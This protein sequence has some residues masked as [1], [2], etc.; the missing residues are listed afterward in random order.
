MWAE[1]MCKYQH[2][3]IRCAG[4]QRELIR[5]YTL[6]YDWCGFC[7]HGRDVPLLDSSYILNVFYTSCRRMNCPARGNKTAQ[8]GQILNSEALEKLE[9]ICPHLLE[10]N[11]KFCCSSEQVYAMTRQ[12][13]QAASL[14]DRCPSCFDNF[15]KMWCEFTC[16]PNQHKF[17]EVVEVKTVPETNLSYVNKVNYNLSKE[18]AESMY[19]S[20]KDVSMGGTK[21]IQMMCGKLIFDKSMI[22]KIK[23]VFGIL[24]IY[25]IDYKSVKTNM[26]RIRTMGAWIQA[27][28]KVNGEM[29]GRFVVHHPWFAFL[30]GTFIASISI[31]GNAF[32]ILTRIL[33]IT[34]MTIDGRPVTLDDVCFRPMGHDYDCLIFSPTNYF[35]VSFTTFLFFIFIFTSSRLFSS[36]LSNVFILIIFIFENPYNIETSTKMSCLGTYGGPIYPEL[37]FGGQPENGSESFID[38]MKEYKHDEIQVSFMA[39]RS[40]SDEIE[41]ENSSDIYTVLISCILVVGYVAFSLGQYIVTDNNLLS[42]LVHSKILVG[43]AGVTIIMCSVASSIGVFSLYGISTSKAALVV[44]V[45]VVLAVGVNRLFIIVQAYQVTSISTCIFTDNTNFISYILKRYLNVKNVRSSGAISDMPA[46]RGFSLFEAGKPEFMYHRKLDT[47]HVNSDG[48]VYTIIR[49]YAAPQLMHKC[50]RM[51][52][53]F[54]VFEFMD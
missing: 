14:L 12:L 48:Y 16:S 22:I 2:F 52:V 5:P 20:C 1:S 23:A 33:A 30:F 32:M 41:R 40:I 7:T 28:L 19:N 25:Q 43:V 3:Q 47:E 29:F 36:F 31:S 18:F 45:F 53:S 4:R 13:K 10:D 35:Q 27:Q 26:G 54:V 21:A 37:I 24:I 6:Y 51:T 39:E 46:V 50:T 34:A 8:F 49:K 15:Q 11:D 17:I 9:Y 42:L 44:L 38:L